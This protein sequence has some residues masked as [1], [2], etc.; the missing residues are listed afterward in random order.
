[1]QTIIVSG[2]IVGIGKEAALNLSKL[3]HRIL[4]LYRETD[5]SKQAHEEIVA[6]T[7][8]EN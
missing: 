7:D 5:K 8:K 2:S 6:Q 3:A 4:G 1:M